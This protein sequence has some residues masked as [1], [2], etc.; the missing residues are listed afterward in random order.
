MRALG[1]LI[2]R[3]ALLGAWGKRGAWT[4][5]ALRC[6]AASL[7]QGPRGQSWERQQGLGAAARRIASPRALRTATVLAAAGGSGAGKQLRVS[8]ILV[9]EEA[10]LDDL[11]RRLEGERASP[12]QPPA[13]PR[14][15][16]P[17]LP[18][19]HHLTTRPPRPTACS[20]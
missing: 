18:A 14:L 1:R 2:G 10:L 11:Q 5:A 15:A 13:P 12:S 3:Q 19:A 9:K 8:H 16:S 20:G 6:P 4:C 17:A 7:A